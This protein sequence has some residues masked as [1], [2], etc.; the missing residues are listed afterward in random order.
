MTDTALLDFLESQ[1]SGRG[2]NVAPR[3]EDWPLLIVT[4]GPFATLR[5][6]I[7]RAVDIDADQKAEEGTTI[8]QRSHLSAEASQ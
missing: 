6:A 5:Q 2:W 4:R 7:A 3:T 8:E 1:G